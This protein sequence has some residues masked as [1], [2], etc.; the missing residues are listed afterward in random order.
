MAECC[1]RSVFSNISMYTIRLY[2]IALL[3]TLRA[4]P[5]PVPANLGDSI[6][7]EDSI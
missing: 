4:G 3:T 5:N 7:K 1:D 6:I 2:T